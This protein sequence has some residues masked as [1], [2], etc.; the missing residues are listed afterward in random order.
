M[1]GPKLCRSGVEYWRGLFSRPPSAPG[2]R[3]G[4]KRGGRGGPAPPPGLRKLGGGGGGGGPPRPPPPPPH[5]R[6]AAAKHHKQR[7]LR[8]PRH[9]GDPPADGGLLAAVAHD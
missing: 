9:V 3:G 8:D 7:R 2:P 6:V 5:P 4:W 1:K